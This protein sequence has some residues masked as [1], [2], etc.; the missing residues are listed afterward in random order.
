MTKISRTG[1]LVCA[2]VVL[3][4]LGLRV[5]RG[6]TDTMIYRDPR[7]LTGMKL[8][9]LRQVADSVLTTGGTL[10]TDARQLMSHL[11][12]ADREYWGT[13]AWGHPIRIAHAGRAYTMI[14]AGPDG[15]FDTTDDLTE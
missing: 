1:V 5:F 11:S 4:F 7:T 10:P 3:G 6:D 12:P 14:S 13:D 8:S 15:V 2:A 9:T